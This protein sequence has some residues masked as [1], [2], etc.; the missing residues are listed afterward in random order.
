V[1][2]E[3]KQ[4]FKTQ[5][6]LIFVAFLTCDLTVVCHLQR[7]K[8]NICN[9]KRKSTRVSMDKW[10]HYCSTTDRIP[11]LCFSKLYEHS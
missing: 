2:S 9:N 7:H 8:V 3:N 4:Q 1:S 11:F 5:I 6:K 10:I